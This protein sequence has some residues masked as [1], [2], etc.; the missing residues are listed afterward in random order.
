MRNDARL[1][2]IAGIAAIAVAAALLAGPV[3]QDPAYHEFA[4]QRAITGIPNFWNV[5]S[6]LPF[7]IVG[8]LGMIVIARGR[9]PGG[10]AGLGFVYFAFFAG[11]FLTGFGSSYY[12]WNPTNETLVWDRLA[13]AVS[14][15]AFFS[16]IVGEHISTRAARIM[17]WPLVAA[18]M[19]SV[20]YWAATE[21]RGAG[22]LRAYAL[23]QFLPFI[24]IPFMLLTY[25]SALT[26]RAY[27]WAAAAAYLASKAP[28][29]FDAEIHGLLGMSGHSI[30]HLVAA[31]GTFIF[32]VALLRRRVV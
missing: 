11:V 13:M 17:V 4:D 14:F 31:T 3:A 19:G 23:V 32:Y 12:H 6:N 5:A 16:I 24:L 15:A 29:H 18:A 2:L 10:L 30:K 7:V 25:R 27:L 21:A 9:A 1:A 26:G 8:A 28:E 20:L 22:D